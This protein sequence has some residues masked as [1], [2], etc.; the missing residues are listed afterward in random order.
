MFIYF[1]RFTSIIKIQILYGHKFVE[2]TVFRIMFQFLFVSLFLFQNRKG[3]I[4]SNRLLATVFLM[5]SIVVFDLYLIVFRVE[6]NIPQ[7]LFIDDT[8]M[9]AYGPLL[10]IF[11]QSVVFK[12][13]KLL[14]KSFY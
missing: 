8:F 7:L 10:Y 2:N 1:N 14:K 12:D 13:Y 11:A 5:I 6:I 4:L 9:L 3:K